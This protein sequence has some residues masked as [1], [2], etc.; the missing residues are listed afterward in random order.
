[1]LLKIPGGIKHGAGFE[2][3]DRNAQVGENLG[4]GPTAGAR[5]DDDHVV[6]G[7]AANDLEHAGS[8]V[9]PELCKLER[10]MGKG[11]R[12]LIRLHALDYC[13]KLACR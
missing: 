3:S 8:I 2:Q 1:M 5:T 7:S 11:K 12:Q 9:T 10:Q 6:N 13:D 4:G